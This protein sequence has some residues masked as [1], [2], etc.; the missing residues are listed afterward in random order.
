MKIIV[1][2]LRRRS[3]GKLAV[4]LAQVLSGEPEA[5]QFDLT[6]ALLRQVDFKFMA[7]VVVAHDRLER[8]DHVIGH[9]IR[10]GRRSGARPGVVQM[11]AQGAQSA[12]A[13][14]LGARQLFDVA[15][16]IARLDNQI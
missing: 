7:Q 13:L 1:K 9:E 15:L 10:D 6:L 14:Q 4:H 3:Q 8:R 12:L 5:Q 11:G 16:Q 2:Q